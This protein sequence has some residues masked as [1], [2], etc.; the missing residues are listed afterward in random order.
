MVVKF[1]QN[2]GVEFQAR[3]ANKNCGPVCGNIIA[4]KLK[5]A[6]YLDKSGVARSR[7]AM[8]SDTRLEL[9]NYVPGIALARQLWNK[10]IKWDGFYGDDSRG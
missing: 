6:R 9:E 10:K 3:G 5:T 7:G 8:Y 4:N 1:C 2:C